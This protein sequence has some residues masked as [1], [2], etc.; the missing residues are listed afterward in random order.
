[1]DP[2]R[3]IVRVT[4]DHLVFSAGHFITFNGD[5]CERIHGHNWRVAVEVEGSLDENHYVIPR[6]D[7]EKQLS[8]LNSIATQARIVPSFKNGVANGFKLF[9][10][11]PGSIYE[12]IGVKNGDVIR[13]LNGYEINSPDKAL[14]V[15]AKLKEASK[16]D[17]EI[18]RNGS[19]DQ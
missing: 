9:S 12:K 4:K 19:V 5:V 17:I 13:K 7:L 15:Y 10:I 1:M 18:E 8:N 16:I 3:H 11:R 14:E 6:E 2:S